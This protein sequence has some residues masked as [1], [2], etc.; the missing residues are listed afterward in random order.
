MRLHHL[1][2]AVRNIAKSSKAV[3]CIGLYKAAD[4]I[5]HDTL[6]NCDILFM[7]PVDT[8]INEPLIELISTSDT[9]YP[10]PVDGFIKS[11]IQLYHTCYEV[12][13]IHTKI[14]EMLEQRWHLI[15]D[16]KPAPAISDTAV[17]AFLYNREAGIIELLQLQ[18]LV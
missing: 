13:N 8:Y 9:S 10:S 5:F 4:N 18:P 16:I 15:D 1:G 11:K 17:V 14:E 7:K 6:R 3:E 12:D 2:Y